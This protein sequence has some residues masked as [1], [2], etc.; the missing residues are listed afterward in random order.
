MWDT[1]INN[2]DDIGAHGDIEHL[3]QGFVDKGVRKISLAAN[4]MLWMTD[5]TPHESLTLKAGTRRQYFRLVEH[6]IHL[7][8]VSLSSH[9][10]MHFLDMLK[11]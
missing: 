11:S 9:R 10:Y 4:E 6:V 3:R 2:I 8:L 5:R 1:K 7:Y